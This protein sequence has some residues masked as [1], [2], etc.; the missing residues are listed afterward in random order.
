MAIMAGP[1]LLTDDHNRT[2]MAYL[3]LSGITL[4]RYRV[5]LGAIWRYLALSGAI[6]RYLVRSGHYLA[7][8][9]AL[10]H[11]L[12]LS[13]IAIRRYPVLSSGALWRYLV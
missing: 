1:S 11:Y 7:L 6:W 12:A 8:S 2:V 10:R 9:G 5:L 13:G 3:V 4:W